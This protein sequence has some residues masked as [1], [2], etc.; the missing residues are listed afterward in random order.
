[1]IDVLSAVV[2]FKP[3]APGT[4]SGLKFEAKTKPSWISPVSRAAGKSK[5]A[6]M[7]FAS[8]GK[9]KYSH[10]TPRFSVSFGLILQSSAMNAFTSVIR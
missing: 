2:R 7:P 5:T 1:M 9:P 4:E 8:D 3:A 6:S 10:R